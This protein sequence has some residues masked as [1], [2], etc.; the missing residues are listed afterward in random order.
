MN[1]QKF[2]IGSVV[3]GVVLFLMGFLFYVALLGSFFE[4]HSSGG[5]YMKDPPNFL[6]IILGNL[7][8]GALLSYIFTKW[9]GIKTAATGLQ[10]GAVIGLLAGLGWD[11][12][13]FGTAD[14][15]DITGTIVDVIVYTIMMAVAGAAIGW[16]LGRNG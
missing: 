13:M 4:T 6:F 15:M 9:A 10:A 14:L 3:G 1:T 12:L 8:T 2:L 16:Y 11:L 5:N 7:A